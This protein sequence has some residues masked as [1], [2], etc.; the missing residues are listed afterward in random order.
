M[1]NPKDIYKERVIS[2]LTNFQILEMSLKIY[3][4]KSYELI[5]HIVVDRVYFDFSASDVENYPL[6]KLLNLFGKL[7]G[8]EELKKRLNKLRSHRNYVAHQA[9]LLSLPKNENTDEFHE[10][11]RDFFYLEEEI[12]KC[13]I[14]LA[15]EGGE[16]LNKFKGGNAQKPPTARS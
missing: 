12:M 1:N 13:L 7:N 2:I 16:L 9:L 15:D 10:K 5:Q 6:E 3:I 8:N 4:G 11:A 14:E